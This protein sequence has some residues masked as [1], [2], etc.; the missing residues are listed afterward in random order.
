MGNEIILDEIDF[1]SHKDIEKS[2]ELIEEVMSSSEKKGK[3]TMMTTPL[4]EMGL[5]EEILIEGAR[6]IMDDN[7]TEVLRRSAY[8]I[9]PSPLSKFQ[10]NEFANKDTRRVIKRCL[11][12]ETFMAHPID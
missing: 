3:I 9:M 10:I 12:E 7:A 5:F 2:H 4:K 1:L 11:F 8:P 6:K